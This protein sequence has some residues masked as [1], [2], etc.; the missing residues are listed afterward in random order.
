MLADEP[1]GNLDTKTGNEI[2]TLFDALHEEGATLVIVTHDPR[3]GERAPRCL[4]LRDGIVESDRTI[5]VDRRGRALT[6]P[7]A[8][9]PVPA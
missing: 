8:D 4:R 7:E 9:P 6:H 2:L 5:D 1:T 3:I